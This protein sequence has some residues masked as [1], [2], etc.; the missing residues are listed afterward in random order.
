MSQSFAVWKYKLIRCA[1]VLGTS[2]SVGLFLSHPSWPTPDKIFVFLLCVFTAFGKGWELFKRLGPF[3]AL[4]LVYESFR[5]IVPHL[6]TRV[7]YTI[8]PHIDTILGLGRLPTVNLQQWLWHGQLA[9]YDFVFY[10]AYM[11]HFVL[12][13]SLALWIWRTRDDWYWRYIF[14]YL[15]VSFSGFIVFLLF[16]ASPPWLASEKGII[17]PI[18]RISSSV[19]RAFGIQDFPSLYNKISPNPVAAMPSLH[20]A[21]A[22]LFTLFVYRL[23][24]KK[25]AAVSAFYPFL[26]YMGT[27]Y[28]GEHYAIDEIVGAGFAFMAYWATPKIIKFLHPKTI[29]LRNSLLRY[30]PERFKR[31]F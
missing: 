20:A 1:G 16:P 29:A 8:L 14:S 31:L 27:I 23:Y 11:L 10:G 9:W 17:E 24:G 28:Q 12:P 21:Y 22:T 5:G 4:L 15:V 19:W 13:V 6:N 3:V 2:A 26:I 30:V 18:T 25:W 7:D